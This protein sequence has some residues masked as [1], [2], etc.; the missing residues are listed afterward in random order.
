MTLLRRTGLGRVAGTRGR[1]YRMLRDRGRSTRRGARADQPGRCGCDDGD[2]E[3]GDGGNAYGLFS[4]HVWWVNAARPGARCES[5]AIAVGI[6]GLVEI[7]D[8]AGPAAPLR[9]SIAAVS[10]AA[11]ANGRLEVLCV[12]SCA[13]WSRNLAAVGRA[14]GSLLR[15]VS[16]ASI[17]CRLTPGNGPIGRFA[18]STICVEGCG[19]GAHTARRAACQ[20]GIQGGGEGEDVCGFG[21]RL[22]LERLRRCVC[23][24]RRQRLSRSFLSAGHGRQSKVG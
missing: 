10:P 2:H 19:G 11:P 14:E 6:L 20:Q 22:H 4:S 17:K 24:G 5:A 12:G 16:N 21:C 8:C 7:A 1:G 18:T 9:G 13:S 23:R 15:A 3:C